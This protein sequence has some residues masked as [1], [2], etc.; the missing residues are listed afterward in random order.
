MSGICLATNYMLLTPANRQMWIDLDRHFED[1]GIRL[2]LLSSTT[3]EEPLPFPVISIPYLLRD[4]V[5]MFPAAGNGGHVS[6]GD[7]ELLQADSA[8]ANHSYAPN[9]A[10]AGLFACRTFLA[11]LLDT[12]QPGYVL[13]WDT[14]SPLAQILQSLAREAGLPVQG[15]ERGLLPE[16]L[17]IESRG[18][19]GYSDLRTHW[20]AQDI[21]EAAANPAAFERIRNYYLSSKPQKYAQPEFGNGGSALRQNLGLNGKK[22]IAFLGHYDAGGLVPKNSN[23]RRYNSPVYD[24]T[25]EALTAVGDILARD[26][27]VAVVFKP[28]PMDSDPYVLANI[29]GIR[30]VRDVNVHAL[31]DMAD[32]VVAQFTT[33]QFEAALYDKPVVL[34]G[35]SAWWGRNATYEVNSKAELLPA[36]QAALTRKNWPARS[37]NARAFLTWT[38]EQF[39]I[40]CT[41]TVPARRTL[42]DF[43]KFIAATSLDA[44]HLPSMEARW[45]KT[46]AMMDQLRGV[47]KATESKTAPFELQFA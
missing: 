32:A 39:H 7:L 28:H 21:P 3:S 47:P 2:V 16:T 22:I 38:M 4:F 10:L 33:L 6:A 31:I 37:A 44:R 11:N 8:R 34:L 5:G 1:F 30:V 36:L 43:A 13:T 27:N 17:M 41:D 25:A 45:E 15:L 35:R 24:S 29:Q 9:D 18:I 46:E 19:Q 14:T 42:R 20:L 12:L 26:T 23:Q 40:G